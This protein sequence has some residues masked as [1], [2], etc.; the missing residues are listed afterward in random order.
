MIQCSMQWSTLTALLS[1][2]GSPFALLIVVGWGFWCARYRAAA[3]IGAAA[4]GLWFALAA[5]GGSGAGS[6][7]P[8]W[9]LPGGPEGTEALLSGRAGLAAVVLGGWA[10]VSRGAARWTA[11]AAASAVLAAELVGRGAAPVAIALLLALPL[12]VW[13]RRRIVGRGGGD[14]RGR[15]RGSALLA[16]TLLAPAIVLGGSATGAGLELG[17]LLAGAI[18]AG[19]AVLHLLGPRLRPP[20]GVRAALARLAIGAATSLALRW[21]TFESLDGEGA[22]AALRGGLLGLWVIGGV[23]FLA[24]DLEPPHRGGAPPL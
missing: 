3:V 17:A 5:W 15:T 1:G 14:S 6:S 23:P 18:L 2:L 19:T 12:L 10:L 24:R 16:A 8:W 9:W 7:A 21:W 11:A 4:G 22:M 13:I 20:A